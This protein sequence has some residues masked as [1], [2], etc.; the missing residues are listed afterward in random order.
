MVAAVNQANHEEN[1]SQYN[2]ELVE[3]LEANNIV[4]HETSAIVPA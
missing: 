2:G 3:S 4:L 1:F